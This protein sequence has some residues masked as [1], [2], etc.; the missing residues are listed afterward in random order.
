M[1]HSITT[2]SHGHP[3]KDYKILTHNDYACF[4]FS[5]P[6]PSISKVDNV[7]PKLLERI[8]KD[9]CGSI[10]PSC[11]TFRYF[12][13]LIDASI[14]WSHFSLLSTRNVVFVRLLTQIIRLK[15]QISDY[16]TKT[17]HIDNAGEFISKSF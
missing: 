16:L 9:I 13:I 2:N 7:S 17:I 6:R 10:H 3:L 12:M 15:A 11:G 4:A 8:Q 14:R 1:M 5:M